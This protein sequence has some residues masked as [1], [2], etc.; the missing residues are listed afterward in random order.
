MLELLSE[1]NNLLRDKQAVV[2]DA[3]LEVIDQLK[4]MKKK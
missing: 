2:M 3:L 4:E 1:Q